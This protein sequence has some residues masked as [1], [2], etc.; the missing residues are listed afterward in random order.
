MPIGDGYDPTDRRSP[1]GIDGA[2]RPNEDAGW[3]ESPELLRWRADVLLD[4]MML[5]G[6]DIAAAEARPVAHNGNGAAAHGHAQPANGD[7]GGPGSQAQVV[8]PPGLPG[9]YAGG[10]GRRPYSPASDVPSSPPAAGVPAPERR[11]VSAE[12][13]YQQFSQPGAESSAAKWQAGPSWEPAP[14]DPPWT[15]SATATPPAGAPAAEVYARTAVRAGQLAADGRTPATSEGLV[16]AMS[17]WQRGDKRSNLLPRMSAL[18]TQALED[19]IAALHRTIDS[20]VPAGNEAAER[21]RHLL[22]KA[23]SILHSD[24]LRSAEV[25]YYMQQVRSI[26]GRI[27]QTRTWSEVYRSRL[28]TYFTAWALLAVVGLFACFLYPLQLESFLAAFFGLAADSLLA[29][30]LVGL[31]TVACAGALGGA[32]GALLTMQRHSRREHGFFDRKYGLRGLV[33]PVISLLAGCVIY[34]VLGAVYYLAGIDPVVN[35]L[36]RLLPGLLALL[37]GFYQETLYGTRE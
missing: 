20:G 30:H 1:A 16:N 21:A 18:D 37:F 35:W 15:D 26:V 36:A 33:L 11:I 32:V 29:G 13:R 24:P 22:N 10:D 12:Q 2:V 28:R 19:E 3:D 4:E 27:Q 6:V 17:V 8:R 31:L 23:H 7:S 5:G 9:G 14:A 25:E 34:V